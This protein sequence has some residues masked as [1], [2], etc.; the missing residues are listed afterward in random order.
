MATRRQYCELIIRMLSGMQP[1]DDSPITVNQVNH[2]LNGAIAMAAVKDMMNN[3]NA[4]GCETVSDGFYT[5]FTGITS[6][7]D[8]A[9][10]YY[11]MTLPQV[12]VAISRGL[13]ITSLVFTFD[14]GVRSTAYRVGQI[15]FDY[16]NQL[17]IQSN[18]IFYVVN[19]NQ[20]TIK[21]S[22]DLTSAKAKVTMVSSQ[23]NS[24]TGP[25]DTMNVPDNYMGEIIGYIAQIFRIQ[26]STPIDTSNDGV[27]TQQIK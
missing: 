1:S 19:G 6:T 21:S 27:P 22:L 5:S 16:M 11:D 2:H 9:T 13:D 15:E 23:S 18:K 26:L 12:P 24:S 3:L 10:G 7:Q 25:D 17:P 20:A 4:L 14:S 8:A